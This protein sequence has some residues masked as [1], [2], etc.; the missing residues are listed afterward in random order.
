MAKLRPRVS[1][2]SEE[3]VEFEFLIIS[4]KAIKIKD[5]ID[6]NMNNNLVLLKMYLGLMLNQFFA[7]VGSLRLCWGAGV[8]GMVI[9][10]DQSSL[11]PHRCN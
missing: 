8:S 4:L 5:T 2:L 9:S 7:V 3:T 1:K 10:T 6:Y 11:K